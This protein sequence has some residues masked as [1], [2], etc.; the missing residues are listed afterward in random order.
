MT[1]SSVDRLGWL[2]SR[3]SVSSDE[4]PASIKESQTTKI[5]KYVQN[6]VQFH[7]F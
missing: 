1:Q 6:Q 3:C 4:A 2:G 7:L 5:L